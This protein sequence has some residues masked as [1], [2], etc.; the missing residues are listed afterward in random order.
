MKWQLLVR[1]EAEEDLA[2]ARDWYE[3]KGAGLGDEFLDSVAAA[4]RELERN[5]E[6]ARLYYR[7]FRRV[8]LRRFPYKLF[9]Q[10][11][12]PRVVIFRVLHAKQDHPRGLR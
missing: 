3:Q 9:Y 8:I 2:S 11:I 7:N 4:L 5:P 6:R 10:L 12:A 1:A